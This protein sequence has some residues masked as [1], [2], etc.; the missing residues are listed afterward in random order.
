VDVRATDS[1]QAHADYGFARTGMWNRLTIEAELA[2]SVK[3]ISFHQTSPYGFARLFLHR[4]RH[5]ALLSTKSSC[6][7]NARSGAILIQ[8][9]PM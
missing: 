9:H 1:R 3:D 7:E 4:Q 6:M 8:R 2:W 5:Y